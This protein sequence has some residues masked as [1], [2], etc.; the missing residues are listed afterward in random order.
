VAAL[1]D[2]QLDLMADLLA[3]HLDLDAVLNLL[4]HGAPRRPTVVTTLAD[5]RST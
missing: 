2:R 1:R 5:V 3:T 4:E